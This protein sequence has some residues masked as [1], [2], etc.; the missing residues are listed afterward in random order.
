MKVKV[1]SSGSD[2]NAYVIT[3]NKKK[4]LLVECGLVIK[5]ILR[6]IDLNKLQG[7]IVSHE[8][9]DHSIAK[10]NLGRFSVNVYDNTNM[11]VG[12]TYR[13]GDYRVF[14]IQSQHNVP[15]FGFIINSINEDKKILFS[16]D[17]YEI[18]PHTPD[19]Q[20]D[21]AMLECNYSESYV[22][23]EDEG[24][25]NHMS[26]ERLQNWLEIRQHNPKILCLIHLS[27]RGNL[28]DIDLNVAFK[29]HCE[30]L[31]VAKKGLEFEI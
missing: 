13:I 18:D 26:C 8:H 1:I 16:T 4:Q 6:E 7:C 12:K 29:Q 20:Y 11:Q 21:L 19:I 23:K 3:D 30:R 14:P 31:Y 15:C 22:N 25:Y 2:G 10:E 27:T 28:G 17:T 24:Y 5:K 9:K